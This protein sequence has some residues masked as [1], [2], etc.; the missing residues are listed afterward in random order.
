M[1]I[2]THYV[3]NGNTLTQIVEHTSVPNVAYPV[4]ADPFWLAP[5]AIRCLMGIG[6]NS[7]TITRIMSTGSPQAILA[8][9]GYAGLRC[10]MGR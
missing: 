9:V 3:V 5:W 8:A 6:L 4:V 10:I 7:V 1:D 2:P